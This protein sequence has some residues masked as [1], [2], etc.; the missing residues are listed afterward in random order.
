MTAPKAPQRK[1]DRLL[2]ADGH[3]EIEFAG[4]CREITVGDPDTARTL[5]YHRAYL[6]TG[7]FRFKRDRLVWELHCDG[8]GERAIAQYLGVGRSTITISLNRTKMHLGKMGNPGNWTAAQARRKVAI[9]SI[10]EVFQTLAM[11][12][13]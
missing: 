12:L 2:A 7:Y 3:R 5:D 4:Q 8:M 11:V 9:M 1:W 13:G 6:H 10:D